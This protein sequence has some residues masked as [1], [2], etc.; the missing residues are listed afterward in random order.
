MNS[1]CFCQIHLQEAGRAENQRKENCCFETWGILSSEDPASFPLSENLCLAIRIMVF[2]VMLIKI[3]LFVKTT[4]Y[5]FF[6]LSY[7][8]FLR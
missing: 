5:I 1:A 8:N 2:S 3:P 7:D 6:Y 4:L